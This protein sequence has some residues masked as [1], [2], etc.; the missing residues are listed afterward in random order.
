[1]RLPS[2]L[3]KVKAG[4][5]LRRQDDYSA[6]KILRLTPSTESST[7]G[8]DEAHVQRIYRRDCKAHI[9]ILLE[10]HDRYVLLKAVVPHSSTT[11]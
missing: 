9:V 6:S 5:A 1:M 10:D 8:F 11:M 7:N 3:Q 4:A 2:H